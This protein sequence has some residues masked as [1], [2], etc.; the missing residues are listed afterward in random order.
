MSKCDTRT[1][2]MIVRDV[3]VEASQLVND[4]E[5]LWCTTAFSL[6]LFGSRSITL[7]ADILANGQLNDMTIMTRNLIIKGRRKIDLSGHTGVVQWKAMGGNHT[8]PDGSDGA[9]GNP[10]GHGAV[11]Y[12]YYEN[13]T[14]EPSDSQ[15]QINLS[16]GKGGSGQAGGNGVNGKDGEDAKYD[17]FPS[18]YSDLDSKMKRIRHLELNVLYTYRYKNY[19][20]SGVEA[21]PGGDGGNGGVGG[22]GGHPGSIVGNLE[23]ADKDVVKV[24][25]GDGRNGAKG[26]A[27][28]GGSGGVH[29]CGLQCTW[30]GILADSIR[31]WDKCHQV[32]PSSSER[33]AADGEPGLP[34]VN[35]EDIRTP[36][37]S[38]QTN[39]MQQFYLTKQSFED[40]KDKVDRLL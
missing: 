29:G 2:E 34:G 9:P 13:I 40:F 25:K 23:T 15:L 3:N 35:N 24:I 4:Q 16:G 26:D 33:N 1:G 14:R 30:R 31:W 18:P 17:D 12:I 20:L 7:D 27:G 5:N 37:R 21:T 38:R 22:I 6:Q 11:L 19:I 10:G 32:C 39:E 36:T 28:T 8:H